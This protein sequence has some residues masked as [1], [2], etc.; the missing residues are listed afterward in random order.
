MPTGPPGKMSGVALRIEDY[1][2]IG[3]THTGAMVGRDGSIDW[4][5]VPRFDSGA[6]FAALLGDAG[7]GRWR[8]GPAV[9]AGGPADSEPLS[10]RRRY[11][12]DTLVLETEWDMPDGT[13]R[14]I[15]HMPVGEGRNRIVRIVEGVSGTVEMATELVIRFDYGHIVPWVRR[16]DDAVIAVAGPDSLWLRTPVPV[17]GENMTTRGEFRVS[18]GDRV[19]FVLSWRPPHEGPPE[20]A[21]PEADL[22]GTERWWDEWAARCSAVGGGGRW[23]GAVRRSLITLKGL[24]YAPTGG[25]VAALTTS[26]PESV[27]GVRNWDYRYCWLRDATFTLYALL[28]AGYDG[29]AT[30]WRDWLLRAV[31]GQP[32]QFQILY[33]PAGERRLPEFEVPWLAGYE[34]S[35]PVRVGNAAADQFQLDVFGE[36][37][38]TLN[39][40]RRVGISE[41]DTAWDF[42]KALM[43]DL[44]GVWQEPDDGIWEVRGPRR[45][46]VHSKV[47][48]W[49]AA[50]RAV[51]ACSVGLDGPVERWRQLAADIHAEVCKLGFDHERGTFTQ[52]YGAHALDA[53]LLMIPLVGFLPI[54]DPRVQGTVRAI[55][56][57]LYR[58]GYVMRYSGEGTADVDGLPSGEGAF[59]PCSFWL[60]DVWAMSGR[61]DE[62]TALFERLLALC[63]DVGLLSEEYD[64]SRG[65]QVGNFPQAFSHLSLVN[66]A[67]NLN[68]LVDNPAMHRSRTAPAG[69]VAAPGPVDAT[70]Q[71]G[72]EGAGSAAPAPAAPAAPAPAAPDPAAPDSAAPDS[73]APDPAAPA[74]VP[75]GAPPAR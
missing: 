46:F 67:R 65:R 18:G 15:D 64:S 27:G 5:C 37:M 4:W 16:V 73:A 45:H 35:R 9:P 55:E 36:V 21:D 26:L 13:V 19:P 69:S 48:A 58:D 53:S 43:D 49:V 14:L 50:D 38:D 41:R 3:D 52:Y 2:M 74:A 7:N 62:A 10:A 72:S 24:T 30:A 25:I 34:G 59:L 8:I 1:A 22:A 70:R 75:T 44:E 63:N 60:A 29:E 66:T 57:E 42:Q 71:G 12:G 23:Q 40:A 47:M 17:R 39:V 56:A 54:D 33:G 6:C 32:S 11:R 68:E 51:H 31:A 20:V 28:L 61:T